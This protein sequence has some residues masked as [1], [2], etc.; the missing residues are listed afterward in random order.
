[1]DAAEAIQ[2]D[3][4]LLQQLANSGHPPLEDFGPCMNIPTQRF[5]QVQKR[6]YKRACRRTIANGYT[7]YCGRLVTSRDFPTAMTK[8]CALP[9]KMHIRRQS[10]HVPGRAHR[11]QILQ[12]NPGGMA[13]GHFVEFKHWLRRQTVDIVI[14]SET[15]WSFTSCWADEQWSYIHTAA[16]EARTGGV[17]VMIKR[18][19]IHPDHKGFHVELP[20]RILHVRLHGPKRATDVIAVYQYA[21]YKTKLSH[22]NRQLFWTHLNDCLNRIP[23]R[24]QLICSGD[25]NCALAQNVPWCGT[26]GFRWKGRR[27]QGTQHRDSALLQ[28]LMADHT[29]V[30]LNTWNAS[31]GPT[32]YHGDVASRID[33][34]MI[35]MNICDGRSKQV[36][37]LPD[38]E[39][40]PLNNTHHI[41]ILGS[42]RKIPVHFQANR[43]PRACTLAQLAQC[44]QAYLQDS[45]AWQQLTHRVMEAVTPG[46]DVDCDSELII[47]QLHNRVIPHFHDLFYCQD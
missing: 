19:L 22:D 25:F 39:F 44:R 9:D 10:N 30:A 35:R 14:L 18:R 24:N 6:S 40:V 37:Y 46:S 17:L 43:A 21:D 5:S 31:E 32:Y 8:H 23:N 11:L 12:W 33:Y 3:A 15:Q 27:M 41:P 13:Q 29:L 45:E 28:K 7:W 1:M 36:A 2:F 42:I 34:I 38:A 26:D 16:E 47:R 20:G 4:D